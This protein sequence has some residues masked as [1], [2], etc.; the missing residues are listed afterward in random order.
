MEASTPDTHRMY[1]VSRAGTKPITA[2]SGSQR[3]LASTASNPSMNTALEAVRHRRLL[4][5]EISTRE[6][7]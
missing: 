2:P 1:L 5:G 6:P 4:S 3:K 7:K